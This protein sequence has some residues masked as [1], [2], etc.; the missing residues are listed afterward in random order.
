[1]AGAVLKEGDNRSKVF[2]ATKFGNEFDSKTRQMT[3]NVR[4]ERRSSG[5]EMCI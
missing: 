2:L 5:Q 3:G 4:G 1:M